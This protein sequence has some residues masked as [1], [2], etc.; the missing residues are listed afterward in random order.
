MAEDQQIKQWLAQGI[1][2]A[3]AQQKKQARDLLERVIEA[4]PYNEQAWLWLS[5]VVDTHEERRICL[6]NVL[7]I[8]PQNEMAQAGLRKLDQQAARQAAAADQP[9]AAQASPDQCPLCKATVPPSG[10]A[11]PNC[12]QILVIMCPVC[13]TYVDVQKANCPH[14]GT[15]LGNFRQGARYHLTLGQ[16]YLK[17]QRY[18]MV[19]KSIAYAEQ[20]AFEDPEILKGIAVLYEGLGYTDQAIDTYQRVLQ[21]SADEAPIYARL[22]AIY[23]KR[24]QL[25]KARHMYEQATISAGDNAQVLLSVATFLLEED[26]ANQEVLDLLNRVVEMD[27]EN[28]QAHLCLADTH[29]NLGQRKRAAELYEETLRLAEPDSPVAK[30]AQ[31]KLNRSEPLSEQSKSKIVPTRRPVTVPR[32]TSGCVIVYA[33]ALFLLALASLGTLAVGLL[34]LSEDL[35]MET[36]GP[37]FFEA[38]YQAGGTAADLEQFFEIIST[39]G[40]VMAIV[41]IILILFSIITGIGLLMHKNWARILAI[42]FAILMMLLTFG[43]LVYTTFN[44]IDAAGPHGAQAAISSLLECLVCGGLFGLG[45]PGL[46]VFWLWTHGD[47]FD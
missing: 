39:I 23:Q 37:E 4:D 47:R 15:Y 36:L 20:E 18:A 40:L 16:A 7:A 22:G 21:G 14:C 10:T 27:P 26:G 6:D 38:F 24:S 41:S 8:N 45:L 43:L 30:Q 29:F 2:A 35:T 28:A 11:C 5:G 44:T 25:G 33:I 34:Y 42:G 13:G 3:R 31:R 12:G 17:R 32:S 46:A 1:A 19:E 9:T